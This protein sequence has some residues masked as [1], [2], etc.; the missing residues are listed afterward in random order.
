MQKLAHQRCFN[1]AEREAVAR[2]PECARFY[3]RECVAEHEDRVLCAAC[4]RKLARVPLL[5]RRGFA[6]AVR[7][8][9]CALGVVVAWFFFYLV[10]ESLLALPNSF[11]E[12]TLWEVNWL[13]KE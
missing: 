6:G 7:I 4:L 12:G 3:C 9:Q 1:H 2:C 11:H 8:A 13:D 5:Q 10:A